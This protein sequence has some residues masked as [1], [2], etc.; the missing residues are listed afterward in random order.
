M[1]SNVP[2]EQTS[3]EQGGWQEYYF[4]PMKAYFAKAKRASGAKKPKK[5]ARKPKPKPKAKRAMTMEA[6]RGPTPKAKAAGKNK[7]KAVVTAKAKPK[8]AGEQSTNP[9]A[10]PRHASSSGADQFGHRHFVVPA[11]N[12]RIDQLV[13]GFDDDWMRRMRIRFSMAAW[14]NERRRLDC[15]LRH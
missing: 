13:H 9:P 12:T 1:H 4:E 6:K 7:P 10:P 3:Y 8:R 14:P 15:L 11:R 2:E 5:A